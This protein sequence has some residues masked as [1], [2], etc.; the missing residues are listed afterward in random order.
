M[1][2]LGRHGTSSGWSFN[3]SSI[4]AGTHYGP[5]VRITSD[6]DTLADAGTPASVDGLPY[7]GANALWLAMGAAAR[8]CARASARSRRRRSRCRR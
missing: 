4:R 6:G 7:R 3:V 8:D 5:S 2:T 1:P